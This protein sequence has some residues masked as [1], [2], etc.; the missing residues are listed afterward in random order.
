MSLW[1]AVEVEKTHKGIIITGENVDGTRSVKVL[2]TKDVIEKLK[3]II[4]SEG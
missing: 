3:E 4:L 2:L 1:F